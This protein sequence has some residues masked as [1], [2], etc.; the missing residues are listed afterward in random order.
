MLPP[1]S[2]TGEYS[3]LT[4][5]SGPAGAFFSIYF[6]YHVPFPKGK[7]VVNMLQVRIQ[8]MMTKSLS[9]DWSMR[10]SLVIFVVLP[11][12]RIY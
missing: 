1:G 10:I 9:F 2:C 4:M 5:C 11:L 6:F 3:Q 8:G 7:D 12:V